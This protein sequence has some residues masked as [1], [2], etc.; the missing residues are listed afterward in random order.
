MDVRRGEAARG[1]RVAVGHPDHD[2]LLQAEHEL[3]RGE[4]GHHLHDRELGRAGIAEEMRDALVDEELEE[5]GAAVAAR[6]GVGSWS[7]RAGN[8]SLARPR[9]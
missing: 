3:E 4:V 5:G 2:R 8:G 1:A 7:K 6:H 9:S